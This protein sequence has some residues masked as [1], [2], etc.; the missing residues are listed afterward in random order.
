MVKLTV[1]WLTLI[2][3]SEVSVFRH[4]AEA[5]QV[6]VEQL[7]LGFH[8]ARDP[9]GVPP[10]VSRAEHD[11]ARGPHAGCA[12]EQD[13]P[14]APIAL[15]EVGADLRRHAPRDFAHRREQRQGTGRV[16]HR[17]VRDPGDF[18]RQQLLGD[19][20]VRGQM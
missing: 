3:P 11:D 1:V 2:D 12:A 8:T 4:P 13:A 20:A 16:L 7:H 6:L 19:L 5:I 9:R 17:F 15:E 14:S 10:D 18:A